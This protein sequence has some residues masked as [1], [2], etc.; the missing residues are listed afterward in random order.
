[1]RELEQKNIGKYWQTVRAKE[2]IDLQFEDLELER[3][4]ASLR[5]TRRDKGVYGGSG[6]ANYV[7]S[8]FNDSDRFLEQLVRVLKEDAVAV[9]VLGNS[10]LQGHEIKVERVL[11]RLGERHGLT[12]EA[13]ETLRTKRV[14]ASITKSAVRRGESSEAP[15]YES[16]VVLRKRSGVT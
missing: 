16:A 9:V 1:L 7:A 8:Y 15:L 12:T 6:W 5:Q 10:I 4:M 3:T 2:R 13:I 14:G 11:A